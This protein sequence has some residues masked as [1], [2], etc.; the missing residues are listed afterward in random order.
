MQD[1]ALYAFLM[2]ICAVLLGILILLAVLSSNIAASARQQE[3]IALCAGFQVEFIK[4]D[5]TVVC[6]EPNP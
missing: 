2:L 1:T 4:A 6:R 3:A 5:G